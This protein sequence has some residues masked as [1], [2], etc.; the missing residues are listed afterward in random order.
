MS[1]TITLRT[2]PGIIK[3]KDLYRGDYNEWYLVVEDENIDARRYGGIVELSPTRERMCEIVI[4]IVR[5]EDFNDWTMIR[6]DTGESR[7]VKNPDA[8]KTIKEFREA[9]DSVEQELDDR[10][11]ARTGSDDSQ[12]NARGLFG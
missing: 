2:R 7:G 5:H 6:K 10:D 12:Q 3:Y 8:R 11:K 4:E 9:L 1:G